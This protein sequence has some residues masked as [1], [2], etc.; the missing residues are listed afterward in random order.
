MPIPSDGTTSS[1]NIKEDMVTQSVRMGNTHAMTYYKYGIL[2]N[3][4]ALAVITLVERIWFFNVL[5]NAI[6]NDVFFW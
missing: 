4:G 6:N 5:F 3:I 2:I 1:H